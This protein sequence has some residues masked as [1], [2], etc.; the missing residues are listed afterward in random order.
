MF[1]TLL[2]NKKPL[3]MQGN[4]QYR[5]VM[6][7]DGT[8]CTKCGTDYADSKPI[9]AVI[10]KL[11]EYKQNGFYIIL[12]TSR[13]MRTHQNNIG[14]INAQTLPTVIDWMKKYNIPFDEI[15]IGKPWCGYKGFYVD[16]KSIRPDEFLNHS[17]EEIIELLER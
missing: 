2:R 11:R 14:K 12:F 9:Q 5:L 3:S 7:I 15:H 6:D 8:I 1:N 17:Y 4:N 10:T 16:D 13:Q